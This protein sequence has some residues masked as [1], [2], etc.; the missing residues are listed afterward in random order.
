MKNR[1]TNRAKR[2]DPSCKNHGSCPSCKSNRLHQVNKQIQNI[3]D[4]IK[5]ILW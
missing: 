4:Q 2:I 3:K 5:G 1:K